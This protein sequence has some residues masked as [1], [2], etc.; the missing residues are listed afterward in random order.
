[1]IPGSGF[2]DGDP[3]WAL[4]GAVLVR[5]GSCSAGPRS[6]PGSRP[7]PGRPDRLVPAGRDVVAAADERQSEQPDVT[8]SGDDGGV[9]HPEVAEPA[10]R[11]AREVSSRRA[12]RAESLDETAELAAAIARL[13]DRRNETD[14][15]AP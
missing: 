9:V 10:S 15:R 8:S 4:I 3:R 12:S 5:S 1:V 2:M 7:D 14:P 13:R 11:Y 6:G